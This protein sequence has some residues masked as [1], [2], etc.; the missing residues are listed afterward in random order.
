M[1]LK[2]HFVLASATAFVLLGPSAAHAADSPAQYRAKVS[3]IC[4]TGI[5][6]LNAIPEPDAATGFAPYL[7][8][9]GVAAVDLLVK[10][11]K[12][13]PP[14]SLQPLMKKALDAQGKAI[15]VL[16]AARDSIAKSKDPAKAIEAAGAK[17]SAAGDKADAAWTAAGLPACVG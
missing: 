4:K 15:D 12:V 7:D 17:I 14:K 6:K 9:V 1:K 13:A 16:L 2:K 3:A 8:K 5:A 11:G 10:V